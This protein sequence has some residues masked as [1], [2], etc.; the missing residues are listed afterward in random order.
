ME[1]ESVHDLDRNEPL[2]IYCLHYVFLPYMNYVLGIYV[3]GWNHHPLSGPGLRGLSPAQLWHRGWLLCSMGT[4]GYLPKDTLLVHV[5]GLREAYSAGY[6]LDLFPLGSDDGDEVIRGAIEA[7]AMSSTAPEVD[8]Q[9]LSHHRDPFVVV[10]R[11]MDQLPEILQTEEFRS[12]L[13]VR[14][15]VEAWAD[16]RSA[17]DLYLAV[18]SYI[19]DVVGAY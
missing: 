4:T 18:R 15:P 5:P 19:W 1:M 16:K 7:T 14:F 9:R 10:P 17:I 12:Q 3:D 2:D 8:Q 11:Y 13:Q 6:D